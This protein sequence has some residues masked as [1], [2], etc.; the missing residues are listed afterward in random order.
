MMRDALAAARVGVAGLTAIAACLAV[1]PAARA[2]DDHWVLNG[3]MTQED[4]N[5][6]AA[7]RATGV[8]IPLPTGAIIQDGHIICTHL[9]RGVAPLENAERYFPTVGVAEMIAAAQA[10]LCPDTLSR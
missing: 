9:H 6:L 4:Y 1:A 5:Y 7:V 8:S 10:E 2:D 3:Y